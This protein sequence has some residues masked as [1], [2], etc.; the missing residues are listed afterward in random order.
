MKLQV[1]NGS[2]RKKW[3][4]LVW[5]FFISYQTRLLSVIGWTY[6]RKSFQSVCQIRKCPFFFT[7]VQNHV[8]ITSQGWT[9][10][11][12]CL[13]FWSEVCFLSLQLK[14]L[15]FG[16]EVE[17]STPTPTNQTMFCK[18]IEGTWPK[19][20]QNVHDKGRSGK[21]GTDKHIFA[22]KWS[23]FCS[24]LGQG[25]KKRGD[26]FP[27]WPTV[28]HRYIKLVQIQETGFL[29]LFCWPFVDSHF[30]Y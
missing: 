25:E 10:N 6:T 28:T 16:Y 14:L 8:F 7:K 18:P 13:Y 24:V 20:H 21:R 22:T 9:L 4:S 19:K 2:Q 29:F 27:L 12:S 30:D 15:E 3:T 23:V 1:W 5:F 17:P 11:F 26:L